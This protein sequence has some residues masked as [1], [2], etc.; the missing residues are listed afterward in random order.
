MNTLVYGLLTGIFFGIFLQRAHILRYDKQVGAMRFLDMTIFKFM[1]SAIV[2]AAVGI[3]LLRD[4]GLVNLKIKPL[5][6]GAQLVGGGLFGLGWG[7][8]G[9]CPGTAV[10][11][12][13]EGRLDGFWGIVGMLLG[14]AIYACLYP[15][16]KKYLIPLGSF[17]RLTLP[18]L[19]GVSPW[20]VIV[21]FAG[22]VCGICFLF[23][24]W[25]L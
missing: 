6:L 16:A 10:G 9:Y 4:L 3:Y 15:L 20:L 8:F 11:A 21:V 14:G 22:L 24:R 23:E 2:V 5:S 17:G 7:I 19:L 1:L 18:E 25:D 12:L 13:A